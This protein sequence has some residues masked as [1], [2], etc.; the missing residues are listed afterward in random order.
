VTFSY[1]GRYRGPIQAVL[2]DWAG[3]T[4]GHGAVVFDSIAD[5]MPRLDDIA[6]RIARGERP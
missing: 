4:V 2:L 5:L 6:A 1:Q 3:A